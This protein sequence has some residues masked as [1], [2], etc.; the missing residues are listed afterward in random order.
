MDDPLQSALDRGSKALNFTNAPL[1]LDY[2]HAKF[3]KFLPSSWLSSSP[4]HHN[5]HPK[6]FVYGEC[7]KEEIEEDDVYDENEDSEHTWSNF[8]LRCSPE[9][10]ISI[11]RLVQFFIYMQ[12]HVAWIVD[13]S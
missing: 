13:A 10:L 2:M 5:V 7:V 4:F 6:Y 8:L 1:V 12:W 3:T 11:D 9:N